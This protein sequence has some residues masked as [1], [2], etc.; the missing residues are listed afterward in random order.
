MT[1][2]QRLTNVR[3]ELKNNIEAYFM[4]LQEFQLSEKTKRDLK[5]LVKETF[6]IWE[7]CL[8]MGNVIDMNELELWK[9]KIDSL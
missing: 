4:G 7:Q 8:D 6:S 1:A 2:E 3:N 9:S 5:F